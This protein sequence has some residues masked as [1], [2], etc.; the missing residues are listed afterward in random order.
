MSKVQSHGQVAGRI[1]KVPV[2]VLVCWGFQNNGRQTGGLSK[3]LLPSFSLSF[4][5]FKIN[6]KN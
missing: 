2:S 4:F 1:K 5:I 3:R 6:L